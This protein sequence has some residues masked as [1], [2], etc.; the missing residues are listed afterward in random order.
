MLPDTSRIYPT[1]PSK[2]VSVASAGSACVTFVPSAAMR[3][4]HSS[5]AGKRGWYFVDARQR[6][7][8]GKAVKPGIWLMKS[9]HTYSTPVSRHPKPLLVL[10]FNRKGSTA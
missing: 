3:K 9:R 8:H 6:C 4:F 1:D 2:T 5:A 7:R 10:A